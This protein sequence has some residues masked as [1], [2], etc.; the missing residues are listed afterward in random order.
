M[1][2]GNGSRTS[3]S[4]SV[5][6]RLLSTLA[7]RKETWSPALLPGVLWRAAAN[8]GTLFNVLQLLKHQ[9]F[10]EAARSNPR[11]AFKY[12][13]HDYL[14]QGFTV[15]ERA[16]CFVHHYR[17]LHAVL[18]DHPMRQTLQGDVA[19]FEIP[20]GANRFAL[21]MGYSQAYDKEGELS[22]NL[23]V[24][25]EVVF[26]LSFTMIPGWV[27]KSEAAEIL[28]VTRIQGMKGCY[29]QILL[30]TRTMHD[31]APAALL[32]AALQGIA[33][34][35]GIGALAA[36]SAS[37]QSSFNKELTAT[38]KTAYDDFFA[39]LGL[40]KTPAGFFFS[41]IPVLDKPLSCIKQGH[42]LRTRDMRAFKQQIQLACADFF[43]KSCAR[44]ASPE[45]PI[46]SQTPTV[47]CG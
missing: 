17:R 20:E 47:L 40:P 35:F 16:A 29:N 24:D 41:P 15:T 28:L 18:A 30:A 42:K 45:L 38:F 46:K 31:V 12:L 26:V 34:T 14:V 13:T 4:K 39:E 3:T 10:A 7:R 32:L 19:L 6:F 37:R 22:L 9:P 36:V 43:A 1:T 25:G 44:P 21:S 33:S 5:L 27:V 2:I 8:I 23:H 11:F